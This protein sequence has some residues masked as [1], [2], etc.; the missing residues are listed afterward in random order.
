MRETVVLVLRITAGN[1]ARRRRLNKIAAKDCSRTGSV[2]VLVTSGM[3]TLDKN[4]GLILIVR[5]QRCK[6][7]STLEEN[8]Q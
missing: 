7:L 3:F 1:D 5:I 4:T 2:M 8:N 6:D